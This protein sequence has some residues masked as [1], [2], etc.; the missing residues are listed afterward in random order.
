[1]KINIFDM[2]AADQK[3][4]AIADR[5]QKFTKTLYDFDSNGTI[6][7]ESYRILQRNEIVSK[8]AS[9]LA[10]MCE[11]AAGVIQAAAEEAAE[12]IKR[13]DLSN[14]ADLTAALDAIRAGTVHRE[15]LEALENVFRGRRQC[16]LILNSALEH[17]KLG[18]IAVFD[19]LPAMHTAAAAIE[20]AGH[21][22]NPADLFRELLKAQKAFNV[23][24]KDAG[25]DYT[26][27][28]GLPVE[29]IKEADMRA[30]MGL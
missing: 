30:A 13:I 1:M 6:Y 28:W 25:T 16:Q 8:F 19:P 12:A 21:Y 3:C 24:Y 14:P 5:V 4:Q 15:T 20:A 9:E 26:A 29:E 18:K 11:E 22:T 7:A 27:D 23:L 2:K 10:P 17:Y